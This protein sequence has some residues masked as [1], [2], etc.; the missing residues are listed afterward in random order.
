[1]NVVKSWAVLFTALVAIPVAA[2][3]QEPPKPA[4]QQDNRAELKQRLAARHPALEKA[5]DAGKVGETPS[6]EVKLVKAGDAAEKVDPKDAS[7]GTLGELVDAENKD[8]RAVYEIVAKQEKTTA[9]EVGKQNGSS[10]IKKAKPDHW[11]EVKGQWV[12]RKTVRI[13]EK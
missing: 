8:R 6:G 4:P 9:A 3:A 10:N 13:D 2:L 5:R 7:K 1:M 12:Q 11:V